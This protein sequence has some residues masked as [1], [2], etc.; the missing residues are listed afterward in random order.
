MKRQIIQHPHERFHPFGTARIA[1]RYLGNLSIAV[2]YDRGLRDGVRSIEIP[3]NAGLIYPG[4][5]ARDL[6]SVPR[7][8]LPAS[9]VVLQRQPLV[10]DFRLHA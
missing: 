1:E 3:E 10:A 4:P 2:D 7:S 5:G 9:L 8:E 6:A